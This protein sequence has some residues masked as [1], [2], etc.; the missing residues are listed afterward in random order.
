MRSLFVDTSSLVKFYYPE[1]DSDKVESILLK[2]ERIYISNLTI[3]EMASALQKK[4]RMKEL[5]NLKET[6]IWNTFLDD[7]QSQQIET[8]SLDDRHYLMASELIRKY[9]GKSSLKTLD[10]LHLAIAHDLDNSEFLCSDN[11]LSQVA[12][13][14][15]IKLAQI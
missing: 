11:V 15:G 10:S 7:I 2:A 12:T 5:E 13:Q 3:V 9:G 8:V 1:P 4:I 6:L 14:L